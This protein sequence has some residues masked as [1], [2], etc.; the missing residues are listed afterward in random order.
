MSMGSGDLAGACRG[1]VP[2]VACVPCLPMAHQRAQH[3]PRPPFH[4]SPL[5]P[6]APGE[7][8]GG[9]RLAILFRCA[10]LSKA[11]LEAPWRLP[12]AAPF[13]ERGLLF[14]AND[15]HTALL[16]VYLQCHYRDYGQLK[17]A[18]SLLVVHN[19]A[20]QGRGPLEDLRLLEV[21]EVYTELF[22]WVGVWQWAGHAGGW[23]EGVLCAWGEFLWIGAPRCS[24]A[25]LPACQVQ[26]SRRQQW[27]GPGAGIGNR[28]RHLQMPSGTLWT[29]WRSV[30]TA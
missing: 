10:L 2:H 22:R 9:E 16:P 15:W 24:V 27:G 29:L 20:H 25:C 28:A 14:V 8:Y 21:P 7:I 18:R 23:G 3:Q 1:I 13:G 6:P 17:Q 19:L 5:H 26:G 12:A 4:S 30:R 11:A